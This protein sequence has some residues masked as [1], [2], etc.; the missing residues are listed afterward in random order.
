MTRTIIDSYLGLAL[1]ALF[2]QVV[3]MDSMCLLFL[4]IVMVVLGAATMNT[5][6]EDDSFS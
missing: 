3:H 5:F 1:V 2:G 4:P 6:L